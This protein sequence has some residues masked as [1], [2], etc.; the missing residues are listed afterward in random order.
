MSQPNAGPSCPQCG[1]PISVK[2]EPPRAFY[3]CVCPRPGPS[4]AL[5]N[6]KKVLQS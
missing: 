4:E 3:T 2:G 1:A 6:G 5:A